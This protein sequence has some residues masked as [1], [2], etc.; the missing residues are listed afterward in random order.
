MA[1]AAISRDENWSEAR[2]VA[3]TVTGQAA[4]DGDWDGEGG[5]DVSVE[6]IEEDE[7]GEAEEEEEAEAEEERKNKLGQCERNPLC[8]RGYRHGGRGG[9]CSR[10]LRLTLTLT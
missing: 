2:Q 6:L 4:E 9:H 3:Y 10:T 7:G 1:A 8:T 5:E